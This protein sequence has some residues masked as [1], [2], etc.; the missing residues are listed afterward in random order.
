VVYL[1]GAVVYMGLSKSSQ[2]SRLKAKRIP[3]DERRLKI[4]INN[5]TMHLFSSNKLDL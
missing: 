5:I 4:I 3:I 2:A 1:C